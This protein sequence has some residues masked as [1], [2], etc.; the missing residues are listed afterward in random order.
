[1]S[2]HVKLTDKEKSFI[3]DVMDRVQVQGVEAKQ[4]QVDVM[5]KMIGSLKIQPV[6]DAKKKP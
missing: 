4:L 5:Q 3:L 6:P 1:M 2:E